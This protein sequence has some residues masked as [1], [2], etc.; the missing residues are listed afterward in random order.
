[1]SVSYRPKY[2]FQKIL[3]IILVILAAVGVT[4]RAGELKNEM[5]GKDR[6][7]IIRVRYPGK[8]KGEKREYEFYAFGNGESS[9]AV[10]QISEGNLPEKIKDKA[11]RIERY[12]DTDSDYWL[13]QLMQF[14]DTERVRRSMWKETGLAEDIFLT[15][16]NWTECTENPSDEDVELFHKAAESFYRKDPE[17]WVWRRKKDI[18]LVSFLVIKNGDDFLIENDAGNTLYRMEEEPVEMFV[19]PYGGV[20][21]Y[22][23]F[24]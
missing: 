4:A 22:C 9:Y 12:M 20:I 17:G 1:M 6:Q 19:C 11:K 7:I 10:K 14:G 13:V 5:E 2:V 3:T 23:W 24:V 18:G 15:W 8:E 21:D 16:I